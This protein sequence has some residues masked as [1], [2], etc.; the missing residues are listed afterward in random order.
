M[1]MVSVPYAPPQSRMAERSQRR[2]PGWPRPAPLSQSWQRPRTPSRAP[3]RIPVQP[4]HLGD[5]D[6]NVVMVFGLW[7][8]VHAVNQDPRLS[9]RTCPRRRGARCAPLPAQGAHGRRPRKDAPPR[10]GAAFDARDPSGTLRT[11]YP[12]AARVD[13]RRRRAM[14]TGT[15]HRRPSPRRRRCRRLPRPSEPGEDTDAATP[16]GS[17]PCKTFRSSQKLNAFRSKR[18]SWR[19]SAPL[20]EA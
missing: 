15:E 14:A 20:D 16:G 7:F 4:E 5:V 6:V 1:G 12:R 3:N 8:S 18:A 17:L 10:A 13:H 2:V 19:A 9:S 11:S